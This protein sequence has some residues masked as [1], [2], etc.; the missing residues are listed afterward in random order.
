MT[1]LRIFEMEI[2]SRQAPYN[3]KDPCKKEARE[4]PIQRRQYDAGS[5]GIERGRNFGNCSAV[6]FEYRGCGHE[7]QAVG[8][9]EN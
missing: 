6:G 9:L 5:R 2:L 7:P 8:G 4:S 3:H 1:K